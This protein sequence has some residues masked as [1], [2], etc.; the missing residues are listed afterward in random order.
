MRLPGSTPTLLVFTLGAPTECARRRL[1]PGGH[2][3]ENEIWERCLAAAL[4]AGR[5]SRCRLEVCSPAALD[6][7]EGAHGVPQPAGSFGERCVF[8]DTY[9]PHAVLLHIRHTVRRLEALFPVATSR[10]V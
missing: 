10:F 6:L 8:F 7:P 5:S 9:R 2:V 3:L 1:L 4:E